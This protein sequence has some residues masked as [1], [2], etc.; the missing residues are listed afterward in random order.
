MDPTAEKEDEHN[1]LKALHFGRSPFY[2]LPLH[3]IHYEDR[4]MEPWAA[5]MPLLLKNGQDIN[6][7]VW[8]ALMRT[9]LAHYPKWIIDKRTV[10][11]SDYPTTRTDEPVLYTG[12][13]N[14]QPPKREAA[15][16]GNPIAENLLVQ[17]DDKIRDQASLAAIQFGQ[18]VKRGQSGKAY[19]AVASQ[20]ESVLNDVQVSDALVLEDL[21]MGTLVDTGKL[22]RMRPDAARK[23]LGTQFPPDAIRRAFSRPATETVR[24]VRVYANAIRPRTPGQVEDKFTAAVKD[25]IIDPHKAVWEMLVQGDIVFDSRMAEQKAK[26]EL[27]IEMLLAGQP[28]LVA[29]TEDH[30][31]AMLV[32]DT[33]QSSQRWHSLNDQQQTAVLD[34]W[35]A[36]RR[37][38]MEIQAIEMQMQ[39]Q[40]AGAPGASPGMPSPPAQQNPAP[41]ETAGTVGSTQYG[42]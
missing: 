6:N 5:G 24:C 12:R 35:M 16:G 2:R 36:H 19:D 20:A 14:A 40:V 4:V 18:Q 32:L 28:V 8:T 3:F 17:L 30:D 39:A 41:L 29:P 1:G 31:T 21:L 34:H 7:M 38:K 10:D 11:A 22:L 27:E 9:M 42:V 26:Q 23:L 25:Q 13:P 15:P 37:A 33:L